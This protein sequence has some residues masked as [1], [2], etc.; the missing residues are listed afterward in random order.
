MAHGRAY[1]KNVTL[2]TLP[3]ELAHI[4]ELGGL[5]VKYGDSFDRMLVAQARHEGLA[6]VT[7]DR[8][9]QEYPIEV[10]WE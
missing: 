7:A 6:L 5:P 1:L 3:I 8:A 10:L 9:I 2:K 4:W